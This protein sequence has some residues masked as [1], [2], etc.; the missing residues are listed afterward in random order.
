MEKKLNNWSLGQLYLNIYVGC[1]VIC[2]CSF[3]KINADSFTISSFTYGRTVLR[4]YDWRYIKVD[5]PTWFSSMT[6]SLESDVNI[7]TNR[8][9]MTDISDL[10]MI[11]AREGSP[12]LPDTYNTSFI[13]L[14]PDPILNGSL[15][16]EGLQF[17]EKCYPMQKN[18]LIRLTNEQISPGVWYF[19]LFNGIGSARTQSKMINRGSGYSFGGNVSVEGC[20]SPSMSGQFCNHTVDHLSCVDQNSTQG[21]ITSCRN[22]GGS[23]CIHQNESKLYSLDLLGVSEEIV[24][25]ASNVIFNQTQLSNRANNGSSNI[26][27]MCYARHG[28]ISSSLVHDYSGNINNNPLVIRS[29]KVGRWYI[30][31]IPLNISNGAVETMSVCY[32]LEWK[33]LRCPLDKA[34]L[35]CTWERYML[36]TIL[37]KNPSVPFESYYLPVSDNVYSN[38]ANFLLEPL[39]SNSSIGQN[40]SQHFGWTY[41][42]VDIPSAAAGGS[43]HIRLN[44]DTKINHEIYA[45]YGGLP[46]EE[47]WDYFYANSTSNSNG[48][49]FFKLYDSNEKRVS[50]YILYVRGGTWSF[51]VKHL[52]SAGNTSDS[53]SQTTMS[54][55]IER[56]PKRCSS[57]GAC[58]NVVDMSGLSL[59]SYCS[60]DRNHGGFDCSIEIVSHRGHVWQSVSLIASNA[61]FVF[62]AY[63]VLREKA[64]AE[65]VIYTCTNALDFSILSISD[66]IFMDFW[67]S[68]MAVVSTFVYLADIDEGSKRTIHTVV[69]ILT[70]LM[71]EKGATRS[72]NI[73][74]VIAIGAAGLFIGFMIEFFR[75]Y[76][77]FSFSV[78]LF[79]NLLHR[80]QTI[81]VWCHNLLKTVLKRFRLYLVVAGFAALSMA[82]ISWHLESTRSYWF[83]HR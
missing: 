16:I 74:L 33:I 68:F 50:F 21:I 7:D 54:I 37:R 49:M 64:F 14:V 46:Y 67:L 81:K 5:L 83:W 56:C 36:Q 42:L 41:F 65:W 53:Q 31:V 60:C 45:S 9:R 38:S 39:L 80:W 71:A 70:A 19:G 72:S 23:S 51:G 6:V 12:P 3:Y 30:T 4:P 32:S 82:A 57:H 63:W 1:L 44:S 59:Y 58:Q 22:N 40:Q 28:G 34:G 55:S 24:I 76:R 62:P 10:P 69:A 77:R 8:I 52:I 66:V 48:S 47:Q 15:A 13:G 75:H 29:P 79:L 27:L 11:C 2:C 43:I 35:N 26:V 18:I 17:T 20:L 78:E 61:A 25:S 73:V